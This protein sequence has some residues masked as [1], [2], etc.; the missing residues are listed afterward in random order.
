MAPAT[1]CDQIF[2][3]LYWSGL[4]T[5]PA[6]RDIQRLWRVADQI[7]Y[8][9][10]HAGGR[11][12]IVHRRDRAQIDH[13]G[14]HILVG[15]SAVGRIGHHGENRAPVVADAFPD[16]ARDLVIGPVGSARFR[17][18]RQVRGYNCPRKTGH[19][20]YLPPEFH[21]RQVGSSV[22]LPVLRRVADLAPHQPH[23]QI[24]AAGQALGSAFELA[25]GG[26]PGPG[27]D[28]RAPPDS[29]SDRRREQQAKYQQNLSQ[30]LHPSPEVMNCGLLKNIHITNFDWA[31]QVPRK[32]SVSFCPC[33]FW[34]GLCS[35]AYRGPPAL[36]LDLAFSDFGGLAGFDASTLALAGATSSGDCP[37][38]FSSRD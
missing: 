6:N 34:L 7:I 2:S 5:R 17:I 20:D 19:R 38:P 29:E 8:G 33:R 13:D 15:N 26:G 32:F 25:A 23:D 36:F 28:E 3:T 14:S 10:I 31:Q 22:R 9:K 35:E 11:Q 12:R 37:F 18:G 24:A 16:R 30:C 4:W 21:A 27:A 1:D